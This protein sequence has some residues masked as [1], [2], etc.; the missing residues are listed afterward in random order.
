MSG[1]NFH[2]VLL[3][4]CFEKLINEEK[5]KTYKCDKFKI[6]L[7]DPIY[8]N[9]LSIRNHWDWCYLDFYNDSTSLSILKSVTDELHSSVCKSDLSAMNEFFFTSF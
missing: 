1:A 2:A 6:I 7:K 4:F 3:H 5:T 9:G 8:C